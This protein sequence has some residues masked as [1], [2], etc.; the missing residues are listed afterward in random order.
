MSTLRVGQ[1]VVCV[2]SGPLYAT[3][4]R[5]VLLQEGAIYT[6]RK[7]VL[8]RSGLRLV[9]LNE[10]R[11]RREFLFFLRHGYLE[12]PFYA[13]RFRPL[14]YKPQ[15]LEHDVQTFRKIAGH[16]GAPESERA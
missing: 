5:V 10:V 3:I 11:R 6:V 15:S 8:H 14:A 2:H 1:K 16:V 12:P 7:F 13:D 9:W 4:G